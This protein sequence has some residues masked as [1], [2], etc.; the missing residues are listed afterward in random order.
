VVANSFGSERLSSRRWQDV[1]AFAG[2]WPI[3]VITAVVLFLAYWF[4]SYIPD[5]A[6]IT[7]RYARNLAAGLG[8]VYNPGQAVLGTTTPLYTLLL[9][10]LTSLT[11]LD[12]AVLSQIISFLFLWIGSLCLYAM[13]R[14][15][16]KLLA[17][18]AALFLLLNPLLF[19][20]LGM[21]TCFL[22]GLQLITLLLYV[23]GKRSL[24]GILLGLLVLTRYEM[25][26]FAA[27]L[28]G[29]DWF[30][31]RKFPLWACL[32]APV[33]ALWFLYAWVTFGSI[34]PLSAAAKLGAIRLPFW[35]GFATWISAFTLNFAW[36]IVWVPVVLFGSA[37]LFW[38]RPKGVEAILLA[39]S[40][41]Y[42]A[43]A[44]L[45]AGAFPWY[46][47][48]LLP[49]LAI[50]FA[51]GVDELNTFLGLV[52]QRLTSRAPARRIGAGAIAVALIAGTLI[53]QSPIPSL[54]ASARPGIVDARYWPNRQAGEWIRAQAASGAQLM[55]E[56]I[57]IVGYY[58]D[59]PLLDS[60]GL[61]N[62]EMLPYVG[63]PVQDRIHYILQK[64]HP[65]YLVL[66][67]ATADLSNLP[68]SGY[69]IVKTYSPDLYVFAPR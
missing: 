15:R 68:G 4:R 49:G 11:R 59:L 25:A 30:Q 50:L 57:G 28:A 22:L 23:R 27:L 60:F 36:S 51:R 6:F 48:P 24:V 64:Y 53:T 18:S 63:L 46:Y 5:D 47:A 65:D 45:L 62:P 19:M 61:V 16:G 38:R 31:R 33:A 21:E 13:L 26:L 69:R 17:A 42:A 34:I 55:A 32:A 54:E 9:A 8:F 43:P 20:S 2:D 40:V 10:L 39:W 67:K 37:S 3:L 12:P 14:D 35:L 66:R 44:S 7:F 1:L 56:E 41:I 58:S 29:I 52:I